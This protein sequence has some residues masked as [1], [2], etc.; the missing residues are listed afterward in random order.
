MAQSQTVKGAEIKLYLGGKLYGECQQIQW[1]IDR[2][3]TEIYGIDSLFPQELAPSRVVVNGQVTGLLLSF[4]GGLQGKGITT[5][6]SEILYAPYISLKVKNR[7]T[8][9]DELNIPNIMVSNEQVS[10]V[11][12]GTVK[13]TFTFKGIMPY[14]PIDLQ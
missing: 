12:K 1:V 9:T 4:S 7:H 10:I 11:T 6:V 3:V 5:K 8:D 2:Q 13:V 14:Q